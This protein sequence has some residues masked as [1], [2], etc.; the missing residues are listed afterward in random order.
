M[1]K[2][3]TGELTNTEI[4]LTNRGE[5]ELVPDRSQMTDEDEEI[6]LERLQIDN[7]LQRREKSIKKTHDRLM[8]LRK[9]ERHNKQH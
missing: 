5:F 7:A 4:S 8:K 3:Q 9:I 2:L 6:R 1:S